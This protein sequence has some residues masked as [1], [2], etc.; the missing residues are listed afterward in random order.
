MACVGTFCTDTI[1]QRTYI[2]PIRRRVFFLF[3]S[4]AVALAISRRTSTQSQCTVK[5]PPF[6][7]CLP[8]QIKRRPSARSFASS[9]FK[10]SST[11]SLLLLL[12]LLRGVV[13]RRCQ[14]CHGNW[15][16]AP[17]VNPA[18]AAADRRLWMLSAFSLRPLFRL[19]VPFR[20]TLPTPRSAARPR[21]PRR[22][23]FVPAL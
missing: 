10:A 14:R 16:T 2:R 6:S 23:S 3:Q 5:T 7:R 1:T 12:L 18:A 22:V 15:S 20:G 9:Q 13:V 8:I 4:F 19:T 21:Q 17:L 11:I